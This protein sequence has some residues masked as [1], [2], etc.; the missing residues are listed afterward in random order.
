MQVGWLNKKIVG[1]KIGG[2]S[3]H[4][5]AMLEIIGGEKGKGRK[6]AKTE[7]LSTC[8]RRKVEEGGGKGGVH[9]SGEQRGR[10]KFCD[11]SLSG[12]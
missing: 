8:R 4:G 3:S 12:F 10:G 1:V 6:I 9:C 2:K 7:P 5:G 11:T